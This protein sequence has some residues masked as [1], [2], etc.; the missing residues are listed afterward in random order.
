MSHYFN[1]VGWPAGC[2]QGEGERKAV[3]AELHKRKTS[4]FMDL[5][6]T[7]ALPLRPGVAR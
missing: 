3:V 5:V 7:G 2:P 6:D 1:K 4:L